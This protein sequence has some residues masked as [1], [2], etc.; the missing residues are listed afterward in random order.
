[1]PSGPSPSPTG[2]N[3]YGDSPRA[4]VPNEPSS[5]NLNKFL[6]GVEYEY[7]DPSIGV[8]GVR[9]RYLAALGVAGGVTPYASGG[10]TSPSNSLR[11]NA[12]YAALVSS[13]SCARAEPPSPLCAPALSASRFAS[14]SRPRSASPRPS[15]PIRPP[16]LPLAPPISS[17]LPPPVAPTPTLAHASSILKSPRNPALALLDGTY[18][19]L[20][21]AFAR[22]ALAPRPALARPSLSGVP[23]ALPSRAPVPRRVESSK[24]NRRATSTPRC[25]PFAIPRA[26]SPRI[27]VVVPALP[28]R[29][30]RPFSRV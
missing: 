8:A 26:P 1:M 3:A 2:F 12:P 18:R 19:S 24:I 9:G 7:D 14:P 4:I 28:R 27:S 23:G 16:P 5:R 6:P 25:S 10:H 15:R 29:N 21:P 11:N 17:P 20:Y 30:S 13:R 22:P